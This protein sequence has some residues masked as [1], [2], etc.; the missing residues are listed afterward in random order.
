MIFR[1]LVSLSAALLAPIGVA[2]M[3]RKYRRGDLRGR[4]LL[5]VIVALVGFAAWALLIDLRPGAVGGAPGLAL[6]APA[7]VAVVVIVREH[8]TLHDR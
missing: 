6:L 4:Y 8:Q 7:L 5:S 2:A 3:L 1:I